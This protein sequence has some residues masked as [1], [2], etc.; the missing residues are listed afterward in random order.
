MRR[1]YY[2]DVYEASRCIPMSE[3]LPIVREVSFA[4]G[5][6]FFI[7]IA[8]SAALFYSEISHDVTRLCIIAFTAAAGLCALV[9]CLATLTAI[10]SGACDKCYWRKDSDSS[11]SS[12]GSILKSTSDSSYV[13]YH[14]SQDSSLEQARTCSVNEQSPLVADNSLTAVSQTCQKSGRKVAVISTTPAVSQERYSSSESSG[15]GG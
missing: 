15:K 13:R 6:V 4:L 1:R 2:K 3:I 7:G 8:V 9:S 5:C 11:C 14:S 12:V 10:V